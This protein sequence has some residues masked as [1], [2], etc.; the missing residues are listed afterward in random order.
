MNIF[1]KRFYPV[2]VREHKIGTHRQ[3]N[4]LE[5]SGRLLRL[6]IDSNILSEKH[7]LYNCI[8]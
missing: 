5:G 1:L 6:G 8:Y 7:R 2:M 3:G 4:T